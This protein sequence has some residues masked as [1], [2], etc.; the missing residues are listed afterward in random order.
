MTAGRDYTGRFFLLNSTRSVQKA[1]EM[2]PKGPNME[3]T[4]VK[5]ELKGPNLAQNG[6]E[7]GPENIKKTMPEKRSAPGRSP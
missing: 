2:D 1:P 4:R 6:T 3:P 7:R 5:I